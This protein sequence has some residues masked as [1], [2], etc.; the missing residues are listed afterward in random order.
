L[1][2]ISYSPQPDAALT[3]YKTLLELEIS[4]LIGCY[5]KWVWAL[6]FAGP[7]QAAAA[8][9]VL[10]A[11]GRKA[12]D[13]NSSIEGGGDGAAAAAGPARGLRPAD[14][15]S[16][17]ADPTASAA[18]AAAVSPHYTH[19]ISYI[20]YT[21]YTNYINYFAGSCRFWNTQSLLAGKALSH[22]RDYRWIG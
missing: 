2:K 17:L 5:I 21:N 1:A 13:D 8:G 22:C 10:G 14:D 7:V 20:N 11:A 9:V 4:L 12:D 3:N 19:Y 6:D 16:S 15:A 18:S